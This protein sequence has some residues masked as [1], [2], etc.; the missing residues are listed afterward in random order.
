MPH[1]QPIMPAGVNAFLKNIVKAYNKH[2]AKW[3]RW[4]GREPEF[5][6]HISAHILRHTGCT[7]MGEH[8]VDPKVLQYVMGHADFSTTM[9]IYNHIA[10]MR[11]VR[12]ELEKMNDREN[13]KME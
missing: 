13:T 1:S 7:R 10:E 5:L 9:N 6:P 3:A 2:E 12:A 8:A 4:E 11:R